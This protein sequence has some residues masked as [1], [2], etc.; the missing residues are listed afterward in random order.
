M[1]Q[2]Q[3]PYYKPDTKWPAFP[4]PKEKMRQATLSPL[5]DRQ[6]LE[7]RRLNCDGKLCGANVQFGRG[8]WHIVNGSVMKGPAE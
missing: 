5:Q 7:V 4:G 6:A 2:R 3:Y 1:M 8:A